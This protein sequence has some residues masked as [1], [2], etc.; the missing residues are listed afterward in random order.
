MKSGRGEVLAPKVEI[1]PA[2]FPFFC[3]TCAFIRENQK[4]FFGTYLCMRNIDAKK[5]K[6]IQTFK[7]NKRKEETMNNSVIS[8]LYD[9][10][11]VGA[12]CSRLIVPHKTIVELWDFLSSEAKK[13]HRRFKIEKPTSDREY[14]K[15]M[16]EAGVPLFLDKDLDDMLNLLVKFKDICPK[17][18]SKWADYGNVVMY[19]EYFILYEEKEE[20][21]FFFPPQIYFS[22]I[23]DAMSISIDDKA[24]PD[25]V[26]EIASLT[27]KALSEFRSFITAIPCFE[28]KVIYKEEGKRHS[29]RFVYNLYPAVAAL[30]VDELAHKNM[31]RDI[32]DSLSGALDYIDKR[33]WRM[34]II[35][36]AI[37]VET[38]LADVYEEI[39]HGEAPSA[40]IGFLIQEINNKRKFPPEAME[41][42]KA[43]NKLRKAAVH[44][45]TVSLTKREAIL[46]LISAMK[47][48]LW[49]S[50]SSKNFCNIKITRD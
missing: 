24:E 9:P 47:F 32:I 41:P 17:E 14:F 11:Q 45:G 18:V 34:A 46:G 3:S 38:I 16:R 50:F 7:K 43:M 29:Q 10:I 30:W 33:E 25:F 35:S 8:F 26:A 49:C 36:S 31:S 21:F 5:E 42:L 6:T 27:P 48:A 28:S 23:Q 12:Y 44:R 1:S 40:P 37:S 39:V 22:D 2:Q 20:G 13:R 19:A 15:F 4:Y